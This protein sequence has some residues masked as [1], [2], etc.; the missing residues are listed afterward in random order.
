MMD[1]VVV[2]VDDDDD[3]DDVCPGIP[4]NQTSSLHNIPLEIKHPSALA[5]CLHSGNM[6]G[7]LPLV[8]KFL[9][10]LFRKFVPVFTGGFRRIF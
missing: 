9:H 7:I 1:D 3:D 6:G 8:Q 4:L 10:H 2:V 5:F